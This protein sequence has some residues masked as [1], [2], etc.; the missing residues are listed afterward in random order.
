MASKAAEAA[1]GHSEDVTPVPLRKLITTLLAISFGTIL[2]C[3]C[4]S[5]AAVADGHSAHK[6]RT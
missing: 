5:C 4:C 6:T 1:A 3:E 2:E